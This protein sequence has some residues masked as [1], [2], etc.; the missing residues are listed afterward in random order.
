MSYTPH[1]DP[2]TDSQRRFDAAIHLLLPVLT[3]GMVFE[4]V[5]RLSTM[6]PEKCG[7]LDA[8]EKD[9]YRE[10]YERRLASELSF[11]LTASAVFAQGNSCVGCHDYRCPTMVKKGATK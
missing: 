5:E 7:C 9:T 4:M 1:Q 3:D 8:I 2:V 10:P 11:Y 6:R